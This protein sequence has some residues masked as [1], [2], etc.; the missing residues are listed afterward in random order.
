MTP[1]MGEF[2]GTALLLTLGIGVCAN[3]SLQKAYGFKGGWLV[4]TLGWS[5][6]VFVGVLFAAPISGAHLNPAVTI[7]LAVNGGFAWANVPGYILAQIA[8]ASAG[9]TL[10]WLVYRKQFE[11]S[12]PEGG[13]LGI[14]ATGPSVRHSVSNFLAEMIASF[15]FML[16][17]FA[18]T[19]PETGIGSIDALPVSLIVLSIGLGLGGSTGYAIN[20]ARDFGPRLMHMLLPMKGKGSSDWSYAWIPISAPIAGAVLAA[21]VYQLR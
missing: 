3:V 1:F 5:M 4:I 13:Y 17:V 12:E 16:A 10:A 18:L 19:K 15:V 21:W 20:P 11:A 8:G 6:A 7:A 2:L 14:F 9:A